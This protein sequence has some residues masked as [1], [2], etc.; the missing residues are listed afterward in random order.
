[1]KP[2]EFILLVAASLCGLMVVVSYASAQTWVQTSAP[3][4]SWYSVAS[5]ADGSKLVAVGGNYIC[6]STNSGNTWILKNA[7]HPPLSVASSADGSKLVLA[8]G[9]GVYTSTNSGT[10]WITNNYVS[11]APWV[12]VASSADGS[13]LIAA[14]NPDVAMYISS[15][16]GNTWTI[17]DA[18]NTA[19]TYVLSSAD[20]KT[21]IDDCGCPGLCGDLFISTNSG[22]N[23]TLVNTQV[24]NY[25]IACSSDGTEL[26]AG[27]LGGGI[28]TS[29]NS[30]F[31]WKVAI[32][33]PANLACLASSADGTKLI[34]AAVNG[35]IYT[36][37]SWGKSWTTNSVPN[38]NWVSIASSADGSKLVA[39][40]NG[41]GIWT[42]QTTPTLQ[43]NITPSNPNL[44]LSWLVPSTNFILQQ[45]PD[46][47]SW[48]DVTDTPAL[49]LTNLQ[50]EVVQSPTNSSGFYRLKAP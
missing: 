50:E 7:P 48:T 23:W 37:T 20:G 12:S 43:L 18:P 40:V 32:S 11:I 1:M 3:T 28:L 8:T 26:A 13:K 24:L 4:N 30:G 15:D 25:A 17:T 35:I 5:S 41:G 46:L 47:S 21:L 33:F 16:S 34:G 36:S 27:R 38:Q 39:V 9:Y 2:V 6:T 22:A 31:S 29:T 44:E 42:C 49:N 14:G 10:T 19:G 45:S